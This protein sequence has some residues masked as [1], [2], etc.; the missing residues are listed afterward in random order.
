MSDN[1]LKLGLVTLD[2]RALTFLIALV[3]L[4]IFVLWVLKRI[5][6]N[7][8]LKSIILEKD[9]ALLQAQAALLAA[10]SDFL[11]EA[12]VLGA[13]SDEPA[14]LPPG[15]PA[16]VIPASFSRMAGVLGSLVLVAALWALANYMIWAA[17]WQPNAMPSVLEQ[18]GTFFL[19]GSSLFAPY[20]FNQLGS[21]FRAQP[22]P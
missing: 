12:K 17:F 15:S 16:D 2:P 1:S 13:S 9:P 6:L 20:A 22:K 11:R 18:T 8:E 3:G 10:K 21:I 7:T 4:N 14:E 19:A 5:S